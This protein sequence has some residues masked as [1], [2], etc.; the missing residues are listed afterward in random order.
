MRQSTLDCTSPQDT[1]DV[2]MA[3]E[4][5]LLKEKRDRKKEN[6]RKRALLA[7]K[8]VDWC[9]PEVRCL[10]DVLK[11]VQ[12]QDWRKNTIELIGWK[13]VNKHPN[14]DPKCIPGTF[15]EQGALAAN[16]INIL[17]E[18]LQATW[19]ELT[20]VTSLPTK[21]VAASLERK[22]HTEL[23][24]LQKHFHGNRSASRV[25]IPP[26]SPIHSVVCDAQAVVRLSVTQT[27][28]L[29]HLGKEIILS[30]ELLEG[31]VLFK[32]LNALKHNRWGFMCIAEPSPEPHDAVANSDSELCDESQPMW[33]PKILGLATQ[34]SFTGLNSSFTSRSGLEGH[35]VLNWTRQRSDAILR[36]WMGW[37]SVGK[38]E[39]CKL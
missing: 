8:K 26:E 1:H 25:N 39:A 11:K 16:A 6:T 24:K 13:H 30:R 14:C 21:L 28:A 7:K 35:Q 36:E 17:L 22:K 31:R 32:C 4:E 34:Q 5:K 10:Q 3:R 12:T 9:D 18:N 38:G 23:Q 19:G 15:H 27:H 29:E 20:T 37:L 2:L 33:I